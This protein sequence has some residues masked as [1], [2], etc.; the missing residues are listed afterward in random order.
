M[1]CPEVFLISDENETR[2]ENN[3]DNFTGTEESA[4]IKNKMKNQAKVRYTFYLVK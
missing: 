3:S 2:D 4:S 1:F